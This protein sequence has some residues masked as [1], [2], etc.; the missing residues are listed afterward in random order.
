VI[1]QIDDYRLDLFLRVTPLMRSSVSGDR[2]EDGARYTDHREDEPDTLSI[3]GV[4]TD[5]PIGEMVDVRA[6]EQIDAAGL[7]TYSPTKFGRARLEEI[8]RSPN[9]I[10]V[11]TPSHV[12][13]NYIFES[14]TFD[15]LAGQ[16]RPMMTLVHARAVSLRRELVN[17]RK[18]RP[19]AR[20]TVD[21]GTDPIGNL[22]DAATV[23]RDQLL[24]GLAGV[25]PEI[26]DIN[27][28]VIAE[29]DPVHK[30]WTGK[31]G[32]IVDPFDARDRWRLDR[33]N[34][35]VATG[36]ITGDSGTP[37][38]RTPGERVQRALAP[39]GPGNTLGE[40]ISRGL[41]PN[42]QPWWSGK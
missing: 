4:I 40:R 9:P 42:S 23:T 24:Q 33:G 12:Y 7:G 34:R 35:D 22:V 5:F 10:T 27:G 29:Y 2:L 1:C 13:E 21:M 20:G 15:E 32:R 28:K 17:V 39:Q 36:A 3:E 6:A 41:Q 16:L 38:A 37:I 11:Q 18:A 30:E 31:D 26:R 19:R 8:K 25:R 14:L